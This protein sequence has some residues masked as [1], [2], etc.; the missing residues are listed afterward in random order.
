MTAHAILGASSA[1]RW[2][3]CSASPYLISTLDSGMQDRTSSYAEEGSAAHALCEYVLHTFVNSGMESYPDPCS[4]IGRR[5]GRVLD[6]DYELLPEDSTR[7]LGDDCWRVDDEMADAIEAYMSEIK[8]WV[9][10]C[11]DPVIYIE[12]S[13]QP[14]PIRD[15]LFGTA[16]CVIV[17]NMQML[18]V[19]VVIDFKYGKGHKVSAVENPQMKY[20]A[21]GSLHTLIPKEAQKSIEGVILVICQPRVVFDDGTSRSEFGLTRGQLEK[22]GKT[23]LAAAD[24]TY[25]L[26]ATPVTGDWCR[27]CAAGAICPGMASNAIT[28]AQ[29]AFADNPLERDIGDMNP[30]QMILPSEDNPETIAR[31]LELT[32]LLSDW[33]KRVREMAFHLAQKGVKI[34]G[35]K[36]VRGRANRKWAD[37]DKLEKTLRNKA[38]IKKTDTHKSV[39][40]SPAQLEKVKSL[41]KKWVAKYAIKPEGALTLVPESD[42]REAVA[43]AIEAFTEVSKEDGSDLL[44]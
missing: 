36:L 6:G 15:D 34:P 10:K 41:G 26:D 43:P 2:M 17:D 24:A 13:V 27:W 5:L 14:F 16:D 40:R 28:L 11:G 8:M 1:E 39:L 35:Q 22:W 31:A 29:E 25:I 12:Q 32:E 30:V 42:K 18:G 3:N 37:E 33:S 7:G 20:Y 21:L 38:G 44:A 19:L 4:F 23:L 9:S